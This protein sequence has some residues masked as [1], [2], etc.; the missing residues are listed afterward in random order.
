[1]ETTK[2]EVG[3]EHP[4]SLASI[5]NL[6]LTYSNQGWWNFKGSSY[7]N[8]GQQKE[9]EVLVMETMKQEQGEEHPNSLAIIGNLAQMYLNN[10]ARSHSVQAMGQPCNLHHCACIMLPINH[11]HW[12]CQ[13]AMEKI[14]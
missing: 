11:M 3:E 10:G 5:G 8:Q 4:N 14:F 6:V 12:H 7:S 2:Q 9:A 13:Y 1:M